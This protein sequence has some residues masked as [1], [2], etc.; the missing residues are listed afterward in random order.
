MFKQT[1]NST[2]EASFCYFFFQKLKTSFRMSKSSFK[3]KES[4]KYEIHYIGILFLW[5][6]HC[7]KSKNKQYNLNIIQWFGFSIDKCVYK[8][9]DEN[10]YPFFN[11]K[12]RL[13]DHPLDPLQMVRS[14]LQKLRPSQ[15]RICSLLIISSFFIANFLK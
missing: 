7:I 9:L 12:S 11:M 15:F 14:V 2:L 10:D 1:R 13:F 6:L 3:G 5:Q 4:S 8:K